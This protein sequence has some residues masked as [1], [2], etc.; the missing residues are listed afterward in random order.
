M[1][2]GTLEVACD[3]QGIAEF[4]AAMLQFDSGLQNQVYRFLHSWAADVKALA[5]QMV[6]VKTGYLQSTIYATVQDWVVNIGADATYALF[7]EQGTQHM[8]AQ[9]FLYPAIQLYL[10]DL[11]AVILAAID[12]AKAE[13]GL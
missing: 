1:R 10:P 2:L 9:P 13:A 3:V 11:E 12:E 7:V 4:Q 8:R 6:P 5:R